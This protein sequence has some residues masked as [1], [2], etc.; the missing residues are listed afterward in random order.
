M[1]SNSTGSNPAW[2]FWNFFLFLK[3]CPNFKGLYLVSAKFSN[4]GNLFAKSTVS[5]LS[6]HI[7]VIQ[8]FLHILSENWL[9]KSC[10]YYAKMSKNWSGVRIP[11]FPSHFW[12]FFYKFDVLK[13]IEGTIYVLNLPLKLKNHKIEKYFVA[14]SAPLW[15]FDG[16]F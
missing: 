12:P 1:N 9:W 4:R 16:T 11:D 14:P 2:D 5:K 8:V 10:F 13:K 15:Y 3:I 6:L 7:I